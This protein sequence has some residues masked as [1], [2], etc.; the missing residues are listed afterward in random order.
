[1]ISRDEKSRRKKN[2]NK[3][4]MDRIYT[5]KLTVSFVCEHVMGKSVIDGRARIITDK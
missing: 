2:E 1:M 5:Y 3:T 4:I